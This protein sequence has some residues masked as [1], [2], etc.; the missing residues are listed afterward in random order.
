MAGAEW[1]STEQEDQEGDM[2]RRGSINI[3]GPT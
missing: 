3:S 2:E 1:G